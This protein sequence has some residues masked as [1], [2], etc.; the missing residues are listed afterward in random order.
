MP[1]AFGGPSEHAIWILLRGCG[2]ARPGLDPMHLVREV[3]PCEKMA[4]RL[5]KPGA[6][7]R[8]VR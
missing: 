1:L 3:L 5:V 6:E 8:P 4:D 2:F 7:V